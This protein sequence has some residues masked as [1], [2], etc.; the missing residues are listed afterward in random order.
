MSVKGT[1]SASHEIATTLRSMKKWKTGQAYV[2][3]LV[4]N[5][6]Y[7]RAHLGL[8]GKTLASLAGVSVPFGSWAEVATLEV[9]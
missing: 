8:K 5:H 3:W 1:Q 7:F 4:L 6:N 2:D 9:E